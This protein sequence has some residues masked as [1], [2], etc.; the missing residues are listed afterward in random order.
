[1]DLD[2]DLGAHLTAKITRGER[3][4]GFPD[5]SAYR[6]AMPYNA[7]PS[8]WQAP[9]C[10]PS[11]S[12]SPRSHG[13]SACR[14]GRLP[15]SSPDWAASCPPPVARL[16]HGCVTHWPNILLGWPFPF[17]APYHAT[18]DSPV[19]CRTAPPSCRRVCGGMLVFVACPLARASMSMYAIMMMTKQLRS[20]SSGCRHGSTFVINWGICSNWECHIASAGKRVQ[21]HTKSAS[22]NFS[23]FCLRILCRLWIC[24][25]LFF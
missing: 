6:L 23:A 25:F 9:P 21:R 18:A 8:P 17:R 2:L 10:V 16:V 7:L 3:L 5:D 14:I 4:D 20:P 1:M 15:S 19:G 24:L 12:G 11:G 13:A 22:L